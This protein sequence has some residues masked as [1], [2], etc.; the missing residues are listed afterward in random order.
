M[1]VRMTLQRR[2]V[3]GLAAVVLLLVAGCSDDGGVTAAQREQLAARV[4]D[5]RE[6][7]E[8]PHRAGCCFEADAIDRRCAARVSL[9]AQRWHEPGVVLTGV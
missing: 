8:P 5:A 1:M 3:P 9:V 7:A 6:A 4:A 2:R